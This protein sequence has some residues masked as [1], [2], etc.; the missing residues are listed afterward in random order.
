MR[1]AG[2]AVQPGGEGNFEASIQF[3]IKWA[4]DCGAEARRYLAGMPN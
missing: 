4:S 2:I 1:V 3:L